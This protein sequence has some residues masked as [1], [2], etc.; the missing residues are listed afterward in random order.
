[1]GDAKIVT[2]SAIVSVYK[3]ER[4]IRGCLED[5]IAQTLF[6]R[7]DLEIV[8]IN[9]G[10]PENEDTIIGEYV[11]RYPSQIR[12]IHTNERETIYQAWNR[13][14]L[15]ASGRYLTNANV[16]DRHRADALE[17]IARFLDTH[18]DI[19]LA[20]ADCNVT[21]VEN[22]R[23]GQAPVVARFMWPDFHPVHLFQVCYIG[24]Q[25]MWRSSLHERY[26]LF[27]PA[28][29]SAGDYEFWL[30]L[31]VRGEQ[32]HHIPDC[33]GL[34]LQSPVG[35]EHSNQHLSWEESN[36]AR[37][38]HWPPEWGQ[39]PQP[40]GNYLIPLSAQVLSGSAPLVSVIIPTCNRPEFLAKSLQ[41]IVNQTYQRFEILVVNDAG[42]DVHELISY[43]NRLCNNSIRYFNL[44]QRIE[45]SAARN[46]A[47]AEAQGKYIAYLDDDDIY[48]PNHLATL[49][50]FLETSD[51]RIAYSDA[52]RMVQDNEHGVYR[53]VRLDVAYSRDFD[54]EALLVSNY[55]PIL[56]VMHERSCL[57]TVGLFDESLSC[58]EDWDLWIRM[59]QEYP[60]G[61]QKTV[62]CSYSFRSD[63]S[64]TTS[65]A[66]PRF[67]S[68]YHRIIDRYSQ[69]VANFPLIRQQQL[70]I[71]MGYREKVY[72]FIADELESQL[73]PACETALPDFV[74]QKL[75]ASGAS[76]TQI[77]SAWYLI[78]ARN[79]QAIKPE[80][81]IKL[82]CNAIDIDS[83]NTV[84]LQELARLQARQ[85]NWRGVAA[86]LEPLWEMNPGESAVVEMLLSVYKHFDENK[87]ALL[88]GRSKK[89][90]MEPH[91][92]LNRCSVVIPVFNKLDYTIKCLET[93]REHTNRRSIQEIIVVDNASCD[94]TQDYLTSC[95]DLVVIRNEQ[96]LGFAHACNQGAAVSQAPYILF[97]NND[98]ELQPGW[99]EPLMQTLDMDPAVAAVAG[100]LLYPDRTIQHAG[101]I[102]ADDRKNG[103]PLLA[104]NN[105]VGQTEDYPK[106]NRPMYFQA[107]TAACLLV[108]GRAFFA[109]NGFDE[110][111][112]NGYED[113]DL[114]F[115]LTKAGWRLVYRPE[116]TVIHHESKSDGRFSAVNENFARLKNKWLGIIE[117]DIIIH[118]DGVQEAGPAL[119][120]GVTSPYEM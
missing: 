13:C 94:G 23:F 7:G 24:P 80:K 5:L 15:L 19:A 90:Q 31:A 46:H 95:V 49:V 105:C 55:I 53:T 62:T 93:L 98:T 12:Y 47:L 44:L 4:F 50:A 87:A 17:V 20:Y 63:G 110:G 54:R 21:T 1:M 9:S 36:R 117:P 119:L 64:S 71:L 88:E 115:K 79:C 18:A 26:G 58:L 61:H 70:S 92:I 101:V 2:V 38:M 67:L 75:I 73:P 35:V 51:Y 96:N 91:G 76:M 40:A 48:H 56:C 100:K 112:W 72:A 30:R 28:Y 113:V 41:S 33:L 52:F 3:A 39:R 97:L 104:G 118:M 68:S 82:F 109:V 11:A 74:I 32:F 114:C 25:P 85:G 14:I 29:R 102:I 34:Y 83:E 108:R 66:R 22:S 86:A 37:V 81:A 107:L 120:N 60:F 111:Y 69:L 43:F 99:L 65:S 106:A 78:R 77:R 16:D 27:D 10:S 57:E 89:L 42:I 116:S 103:I 6:R 84:A 59:A 8:I 45:R